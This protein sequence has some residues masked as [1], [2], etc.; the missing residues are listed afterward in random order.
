MAG[1]APAH[2]LTSC[3]VATPCL[4]LNA[5]FSSQLPSGN[6]ALFAGSNSDFILKVANVS[7]A[8]SAAAIF[9][10]SPG[11]AVLGTTD[12]GNT[13][14]GVQ[15]IHPST[16][17]VSPGVFGL[18]NSGEDG[19]YAVRGEIPFNTGVRSAGVFGVQLNTSSTLQFNAGVHGRH[20]GAGFGV[21]GE[22]AKRMGVYGVTYASSG[23]EPGVKGYSASSSAL[24]AGVG[25]VYGGSS[26]LGAGVYGDSANGIG[27]LGIGGNVGVLGYNAN[28][29][30]LAGYF[31]GNVHVN[32]TLSKSAGSFRIDHP[33]DP[34]NKYLQHSFVES[35]DMKNVYDGV[36]TT[37][38]RG[39]ATVRLP[40]YFQALNRSFRY[41]LTPLGREAW[42]ARAGI[43]QEI[44]DNRF[45]IRSEPRTKISWQVTG[46]RKD[47]YANAHRIQPEV[48]K[49][50]ADRGLYLHPELYGKP[51]SRGLM[52]VPTALLRR[53]R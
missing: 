43:W 18:T 48:A 27:A 11:V 35:P 38:G 15:G 37:D 50:A 16:A 36:V 33:L 10:Y 17:G 12:F 44:R 4:P 1:A 19:A 9:A 30:G 2:A 49:P 6:T 31:L 25:G 14:A 40:H 46:I 52:R 24:A 34:A 28:P 8:P 7:L 13:G 32:G 42:D 26:T 3:T 22:S 41:Q 51:P 45:V 23:T 20:E 5:G 29:G 47:R 53:A 21:L 39:F